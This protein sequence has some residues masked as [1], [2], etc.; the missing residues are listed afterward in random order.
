MQARIIEQGHLNSAVRRERLGK[1][2]VH[3]GRDLGV[4]RS[5]LSPMDGLARAVLDQRGDV[6][7]T[8]IT[9]WS[10]TAT[11]GNQHHQRTAQEERAHIRA[12]S[13]QAHAAND[14]QPLVLVLESLASLASL[15]SLE[16]LE[17]TLAPD[18]T[19]HD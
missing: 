10:A 14:P 5:P 4:I 18:L 8:L 1:Q 13:L 15:E 2:I 17:S 6:A 12:S 19:C 11:Q 9:R 7:E 16:S 3:G